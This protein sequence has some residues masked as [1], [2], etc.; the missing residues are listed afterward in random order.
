MRRRGERLADRIEELAA[1][2]IDDLDGFLAE[3]EARSVP[4]E[5]VS[6]VAD[7]LHLEYAVADPEREGILEVVGP[8][9]GAYASLVDGGFEARALE[10]V[11]FEA[12]GATFGSVEVSTAWAEAYLAGRLTAG[13]YGELVAGT[14]ESAREP[15][16]PDVAPE[17]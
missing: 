15:P 2:P 12:D 16:E 14:I 8:V 6:E 11:A 9:A 3:L 17:E 1:A 10:L 5:A 13:E 4:F 7:Q